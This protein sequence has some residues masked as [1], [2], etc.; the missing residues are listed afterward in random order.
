MLLTHRA[1][2]LNVFPRER[3]PRNALWLKQKLLVL[4]VDEEGAN[5]ENNTL[6]MMASAKE[7]CGRKRKNGN[8]PHCGTR[9]STLSGS[10]KTGYRRQRTQQK[11]GAGEEMPLI[12]KA[13]L[14]HTL[15]FT[16]VNL[17]NASCKLHL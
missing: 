5:E 17:V 2:L 3:D 4:A 9:R 1:C 15:T 8:E 16:G 13:I 7:H 10:H 14:I 11:N 12:F 6:C